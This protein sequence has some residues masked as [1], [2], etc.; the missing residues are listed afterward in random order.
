MLCAAFI[1]KYDFYCVFGGKM[2]R[3]SFD[4]DLHIHSKISLCSNDAEQTNKRILQYAKQ[5]NLKTICLT[6]HFWDE[7]VEFCEENQW[8]AEQNF[9]HISAAK[10]LPQADGIDFLFGCETE[11][12]YNMNLGIGRETFDRFDFVVVPTTHFHMTGFTIPADLKINSRKKR[13]GNRA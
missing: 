10:P 6:D 2:M 12:D 4:N 13:C 3:Y 1:D 7:N 11:M 8:Y 5:N 9:E